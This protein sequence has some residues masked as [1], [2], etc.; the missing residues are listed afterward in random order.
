MTWSPE[1]NTGETATGSAPVIG[2]GT[3]NAAVASEPRG[4]RVTSDSTFTIRSYA[5]P[6]A[7]LGRAEP[8]AVPGQALAGKTA[9]GV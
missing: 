6:L 2:A 4:G 3:A 9:A 1:M 5:E 8:R 7:A